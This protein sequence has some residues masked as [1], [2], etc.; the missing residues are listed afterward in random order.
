[1]QKIT[2][3]LWFDTNAEQAVAFYTSIFGNS[4]TGAIARYGE[5][6]AKVSGLPKGSVMT[7]DFEIEGF[8]FVALNGGPLFK[9]TPAMGRY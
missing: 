6:G 2:P 9:F 5:S 4:K 1:M 8:K 3:N 7:V